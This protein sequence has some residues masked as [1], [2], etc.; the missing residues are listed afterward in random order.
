MLL[1]SGWYRG[2]IGFRKHRNHY[3]DRLA[4]LAQLDITYTDGSRETIASDAQWKAA[5]SP[6]Q[7]A[8]I[9]GGET[10]DA[11]LEKTGWDAPGFD[12]TELEG[13]PRRRASEEHADRT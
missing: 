11:R 8:E 2:Q 9:Y 3:G 6:I 12:D 5:T 10:Y 4:L 7:T 1:G 13:R